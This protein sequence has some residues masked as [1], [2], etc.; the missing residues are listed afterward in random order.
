MILSLSDSVATM[1]YLPCV[2][3][4]FFVKEG[5]GFAATSQVLHRRIESMNAYVVA[6][7]VRRHGFVEI[8]PPAVEE[9]LFRNETEP[10][11][12][13]KRLVVHHFDQFLGADPLVVIDFVRVRLDGQISLCFDT[14]EENIVNLVF[15]PGAAAAK[16][17]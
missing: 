2:A 3:L 17:K 7:L 11:R 5:P 13:E 15:S 6:V 8:F 4:E 16:N 1:T 14:K 10:R 12:K 9:P